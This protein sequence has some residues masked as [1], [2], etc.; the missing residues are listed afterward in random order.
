M[1]YL[2]PSG[3]DPHL[4]VDMLHD[5]GHCHL[6]QR[7]S[8]QNVL[9]LVQNPPEHILVRQTHKRKSR[10]SLKARIETG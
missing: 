4:I 1:G 7:R 10:Q 6:A 2:F 3:V 5:L 8:H 9:C